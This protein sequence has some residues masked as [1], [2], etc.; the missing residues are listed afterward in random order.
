MPI[1]I[2]NN[3]PCVDFALGHESSGNSIYLRMLVD[4]GAAMNSGNEAYHSQ[5]MS[6]FLEITKYDLVQLKVAA[7]Q[8]ATEVDFTNGTLSVIIRV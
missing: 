8:S 4:S 3:L 7:T 1:N 6:Q 2:D 5:I